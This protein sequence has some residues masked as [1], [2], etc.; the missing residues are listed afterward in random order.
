MIDLAAPQ[1]QSVLAIVFLAVRLIRRLGFTQ[2][3]L[4]A[5][6]VIRGAADGRLVLLVTAAAILLGAAS[7]L[8]WW[9]YTFRLVGDEL[10]V[11]KGVVRVERLTIPFDRIQSVSIDQELLHRLTG[12]VK[13][14]V[15]TAGSSAAEFT[16]DAVERPVAEE[17]QRQT[18]TAGAGRATPRLGSD[19]DGPTAE[20]LG[21]VVFRHDSQ[22]LLLAALTSPPWTA[23]V[24]L[25]PIVAFGSQFGGSVP[26]IDPGPFRWWWIPILATAFLL[27]SLVLNL[28]SVLL[29]H[30]DL[31]LR[32]EPSVLRRTSG[33]L[34]RTSRASSPRRVQATSTS[35]NPLQHRAGL[36]T[37]AL[38]SIGDGDLTLIGCDDAQVDV[39]H[40]LAGSAPPSLL[41]LDRRVERDEVWLAVRNASI[42]AG[43]I[44]LA[45]WF[46]IGWWSLLVLLVVPWRWMTSA[47]HVRTFRWSLDEQFATRSHVIMRF[48]NQASL[49]KANGVRITQSIFERRRGL[50]RVHL[51]TAAG[52]VA[53]GMIPIDDAR[54]VRDVVLHAAETSRRDW[55]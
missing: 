2:L 25:G 35:Q 1:R 23:L 34:S 10:V 40:R 39:V 54:T 53:V 11:T 13:V 48:T 8:A 19:A 44:S 18:L 32:S 43:L 51:D 38:S 14:M 29:Q 31:T 55:M 6:F 30:W 27:L 17:L 3:A 20:S 45:A 5:F 42:V 12:L 46:A 47:R 9:R 15:D 24:V 37:V 52:T 26:S 49:H 36:R 28:A 16:I 4:V 7:T 21:H 50:G 41:M 33:L 22:R